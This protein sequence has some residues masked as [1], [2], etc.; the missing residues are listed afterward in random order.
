MMVTL[1][2]VGTILYIVN[3][4][5][6]SLYSQW[7]RDVYYLGNLLAASALVVSSSAIQ[8]WQAVAINGFWAII[9]LLMLASV[10]LRALAFGSRRAQV[11][12]SGV[13]A[14]A[15]VAVIKSPDQL[16]NALNWIAAVIFALAYLMF[17]TDKMRPRH[18]QL[19]NM[20][21]ALMTLPSLWQQQNYSVFCLEVTWAGLS[22]WAAYKKY[23]EA[24]I[25][26]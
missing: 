3:H 22:A 2:W 9:S 17:C 19:A 24:H 14:I 12:M 6:L 20:I 11:L 26:D 18:Y 8:S 16:W 7:R 4:A 15:A 23:T 10:S 25:V 21:A 5:Y 13:I 1:G